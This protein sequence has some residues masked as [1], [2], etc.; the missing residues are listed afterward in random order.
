VDDFAD[1]VTLVRLLR[2]HEVRFVVIG[3]WGANF[4]A[5]AAGA[6]FT[7]QGRNLF[8]PPDADNLMRAWDA[9]EAGGLSQ[10]P[11]PNSVRTEP[12]GI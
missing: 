3:V 8:L 4:F 12:S 2:E 9:C 10:R 7:T 11:S 1:F 5:H 6:V